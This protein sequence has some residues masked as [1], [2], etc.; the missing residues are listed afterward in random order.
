MKPVK[1]KTVWSSVILTAAFSIVLLVGPML[2]GTGNAQGLIVSVLVMGAAL[3]LS[4]LVWAAG[5]TDSDHD[6][7]KR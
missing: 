3:V 2:G 5:S 7:H 1:K 4:T 6:H